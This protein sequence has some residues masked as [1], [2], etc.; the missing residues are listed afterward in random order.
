MRARTTHTQ[1][2]THREVG[3]RAC[4]ND[5]LGELTRMSDQ[6]NVCVLNA[7]FCRGHHERGMLA[8]AQGCLSR[9]A[10]FPDFQRARSSANS[11]EQ[12]SLKGR[13]SALQVPSSTRTQGS[14]I[15]AHAHV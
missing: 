2:A 11:S 5:P 9:A 1:S 15:N 6:A 12:L 7:C 10:P 4:T 3:R 14:D 8:H 13:S